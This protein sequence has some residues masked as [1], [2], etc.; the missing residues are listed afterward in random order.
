VRQDFTRIKCRWQ[1]GVCPP[2]L[3]R[4]QQYP[5]PRSTEPA[6]QVVVQYLQPQFTRPTCPGQF[7]NGKTCG[8]SLAP[9]A[10][11]LKQYLTLTGEWNHDRET[12]TQ[13]REPRSDSAGSRITV[14]RR[15]N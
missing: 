15:R 13:G 11:R 1:S 7:Q 6:E 2:Y 5:T 4:A 8:R 10:C 3:P 14:R 12:H 9:G